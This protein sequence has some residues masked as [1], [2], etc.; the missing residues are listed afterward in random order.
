MLDGISWENNTK[1]TNIVDYIPE[2]GDIVE[3]RTC[4][5]EIC[6]GFY[7]LPYRAYPNSFFDPFKMARWCEVDFE[8]CWHPTNKKPIEWKL[9]ANR[10]SESE[11]N[12]LYGYYYNTHPVWFPKYN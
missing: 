2:R 5:G 12:F 1:Y 4:D 6:V 10:G 8:G 3:F 9:L 11:K 7:T